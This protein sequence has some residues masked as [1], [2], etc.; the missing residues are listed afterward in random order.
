MAIYLNEQKIPGYQQKVA[1]T[2]SLAG[3]DLSGQS[4]GS[5]QAEAGDKP[6]ALSIST[7]IKF[8]DAKDLSL[9]INLAEARNANDERER[10]TIINPT[11]KAMNIR[12][13]SFQGDVSVRESDSLEAWAVSFKL[14]EFQSVPEKKEQ[15]AL[16]K[17]VKEQAA[18][19]EPIVPETP[20][21]EEKPEE[22]L[23]FFEEHV[24]KKIDAVL[25]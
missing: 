4:S 9:L 24:L 3:Q 13:V 14:I 16:D 10:Y 23:S 21:V 17:P 19:D 5:Q 11:A 7:N 8:D 2:L 22:Q 25:G 15:R 20:V 12:Q 1:A 6:K 18:V